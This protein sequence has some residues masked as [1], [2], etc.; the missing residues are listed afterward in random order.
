MRVSSRKEPSMELLPA[1]MI[2]FGVMV[3]AI[4][5]ALGQFWV[6]PAIAKSIKKTLTI[7]S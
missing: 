1:L 7:S 4:L 2:A 5:S 3:S 6:N